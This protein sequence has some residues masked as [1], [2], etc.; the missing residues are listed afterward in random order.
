MVTINYRLGALGFLAHPALT[1]ES[2]DHISGNYGIEDQQV[3]LKW[4]RTNIRAFGGDPQRVTMFGESAGGLSTFTNLVSP[5][6]N[7]LFHRAIAESGAYMLT[8]PTLA[9]SETAGTAFANASGCNQSTQSAVLACLRA[10]PIAT[11]L[12]NQALTFPAGSLGPSPNVDGKVLTQS[13]GTALGSGQFNRVPLLH[14]TN[15]SEW[16]L[17][18][19]EDFDLAGGPVNAATYVPA[20]AATIGNAAVA[21]TVAARY[22]VPTQFPTFDQGV[23]GVGTDAIFA[24]AAHFADELASQFVPTFAYEFNDPK[25]SAELPAS[26]ELHIRRITRLGDLV[27]LPDRQPVGIRFEPS[28]DAARREP[29]KTVGT[30]GR[31]LDGVRQDRRPQRTRAPV[32]A[33]ALAAL[34]SQPTGDAV[35]RPA[36]PDPGDDLCN[37]PPVRFLGHPFGSLLATCRR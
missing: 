32:R 11:I 20:I 28:A 33:T 12:A 14:G 15:H 13:I 16:N 31:L 17:F 34:Q 18:V 35:A 22:P 5:T 29:A 27:S 26:G 21:P 25:S 30:H 23:G 2:P 24:C 6:A 1:G 19:A 37:H 4:V 3:A 10:L 7:G 9:Q 36:D 8:L